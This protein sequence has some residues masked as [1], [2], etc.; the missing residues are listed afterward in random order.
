MRKS[1]GTCFRTRRMKTIRCSLSEEDF[2]NVE[3]ARTRAAQ[4]RVEP[5]LYEQLRVLLCPFL[6]SS[7]TRDLDRVGRKFSVGERADD[8]TNAVPRQSRF[9][10]TEPHNVTQVPQQTWNLPDLVFVLTS[11]EKYLHL[12]FVQGRRDDLSAEHVAAPYPDV[13]LHGAVVCEVAVQLDYL[14][15]GE[16]VHRRRAVERDCLGEDLRVDRVAA[17]PPRVLCLQLAEEVRGY[18]SLGC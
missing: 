5:A 16:A 17:E 13:V 6:V 10:V 11:P 3:V 7:D 14:V 1:A 12:L 4:T 9:Q 8:D 15:E 18:L 2:A